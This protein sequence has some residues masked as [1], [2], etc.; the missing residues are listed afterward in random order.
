LALALG[1]RTPVLLSA[2][3][4]KCAGA[5]AAMA[6]ERDPET[7]GA[8]L[9]RLALDAHK[10]AR[11]RDAT[12]QFGRGRTWPEIARRHLGLYEEVIRGKGPSDR[13]VRTAQ[14]R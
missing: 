11:L 1:Y 6:F 2:E 14:S 4:A 3:L 9:Q 8:R 13:S 10:R 12:E 5:P 7:L